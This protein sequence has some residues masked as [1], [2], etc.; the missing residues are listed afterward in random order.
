MVFLDSF[1]VAYCAFSSFDSFEPPSSSL[2][3]VG[4]SYPVTQEP[5]VLE[6]I[7]ELGELGVL[8]AAR[9]I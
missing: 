3:E 1:R 5:A 7:E 6:E 4:N 8:E 2:V 9:V